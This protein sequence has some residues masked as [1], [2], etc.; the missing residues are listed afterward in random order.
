[1]REVL[2]QLSGGGIE[3]VVSVIG[4]WIVSDESPKALDDPVYVGCAAGLGGYLHEDAV[5]DFAVGIAK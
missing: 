4:F 1:M 3:V 5:Q 2:E